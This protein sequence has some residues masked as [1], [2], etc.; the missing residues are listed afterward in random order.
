M[1]KLISVIA[2]TYILACIFFLL[3]ISIYIAWDLAFL[4]S[5]NRAEATSSLIRILMFV[6]VGYPVMRILLNKRRARLI[7]MLKKVAPTDY[8]AT[9]EVI[10]PHETEYFGMSPS[11]NKLVVIDL[12]RK[13]ARCEDYS[14]LQKWKIEDTGSRSI[15][16]I[17]FNDYDFSILQIAVPERHRDAIA[18][19]LNLAGNS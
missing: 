19:R 16:T 11:T 2:G 12:K 8:K 6:V 4:P 13:V 1:A 10:G 3:P 17:S 18:A 15:L 14:F 5:V 7:S 9:V